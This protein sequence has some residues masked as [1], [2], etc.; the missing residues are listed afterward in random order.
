M[1]SMKLADE[2][3]RTRRHVGFPQTEGSK[4]HLKKRI[5]TTIY[6]WG[7][8]RSSKARCFRNLR[9]L[10]K[11]E[12]G[13]FP[14]HS[15]DEAVVRTR[16]PSQT[17]VVCQARQLQRH[18]VA[19]QGEGSATGKT[20]PTLTGNHGTRKRPKAGLASPRRPAVLR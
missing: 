2:F 15:A 1:R 18:G 5:T 16:G 3:L 9:S 6:L 10:G 7:M 17:L 19:Q 4:T 14:L 11:Q 20:A 12:L 8:K 13:E